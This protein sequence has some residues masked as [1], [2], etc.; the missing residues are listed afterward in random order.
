MKATAQQR[1]HR[2]R[3]RDSS[4]VGQATTDEPIDTTGTSVLY[5]QYARTRWVGRGH[6]IGSTATFKPM[7]CLFSPVVLEVALHRR[8]RATLAAGATKSEAAGADGNRGTAVPPFPQR[9]DCYGIENKNNGRTSEA[10]GLHPSTKP[11][12]AHSRSTKTAMLAAAKT[13]V[14]RPPLAAEYAPF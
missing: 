14:L 13:K 10:S 6:G 8:H 11:G 1:A 4:I 3:R 5:L 2:K 9:Y 7:S 12:R